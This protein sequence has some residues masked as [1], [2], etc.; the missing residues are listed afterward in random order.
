MDKTVARGANKQ[1]CKPKKCEVLE[2]ITNFFFSDLV[3]SL[4]NNCYVL[5]ILA[6]LVVL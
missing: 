1:N 3:L 2:N 4:K 6:T 5:N